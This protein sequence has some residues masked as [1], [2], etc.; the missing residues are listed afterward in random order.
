MLKELTAIGY[1]IQDAIRTS[2]PLAAIQVDP[3][4]SSRRANRCMLQ[5]AR[6]RLLDGSEF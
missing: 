4:G 2:L 5:V 1:T 6:N 3:I